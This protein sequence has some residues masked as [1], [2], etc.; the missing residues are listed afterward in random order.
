MTIIKLLTVKAISDMKNIK[1]SRKSKRKIRK[2]ANSSVDAA[3]SVVA[4]VLRGMRK[5]EK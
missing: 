2:A 3:V 5:N 1:L 4:D